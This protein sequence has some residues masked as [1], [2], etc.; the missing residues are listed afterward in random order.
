MALVQKGGRGRVGGAEGGFRAGL[1][2]RRDRNVL[3]GQGGGS[4]SQKQELMQLHPYRAEQDLLWG[5]KLVQHGSRVK[6]GWEA[7][8]KEAGKR[9]P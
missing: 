6:W 9:W 7:V 8:G 4:F 3:C 1:R 2:L 5:L